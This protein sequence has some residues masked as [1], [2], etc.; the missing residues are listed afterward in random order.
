MLCL[1]F[2]K[3]LICDFY[4]QRPYQYLNK[5]KYGHPGGLLHAAIHTVGSLIC[6]IYFMNLWLLAIVLLGEFVIHYHTDWAKVN[7]CKHFNWKMDNSEQYWWMLGV[8]QTI[9][10]LTYLVMFYACC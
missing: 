1:L 2:L 10:S 5:G 3:H 7:I 6:C 8:D 4:L 9:H